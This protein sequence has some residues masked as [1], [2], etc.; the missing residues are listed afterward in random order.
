MKNPSNKWA[1]VIAMFIAVGLLAACSAAETSQSTE[2]PMVEEPTEIPDVVEPTSPPP[3]ID[4]KVLLEQRCT[5]C[6]NLNRVMNKSW[7][8]EQWEQTV[9]DMIRRGAQLNE[10]EKDALV[11]YLAE[12][13]GP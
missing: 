3:A 2:T 11:K 1:I 12:E 13:Y 4:G 7:P 8:L 10:E 6:H 5:V 9:S